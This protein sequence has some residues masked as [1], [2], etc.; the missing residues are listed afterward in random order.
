MKRNRKDFLKSKKSHRYW[1]TKTDDSFYVGGWKF[2]SPDFCNLQEV[3]NQTPKEARAKNSSYEEK[4]LSKPY[5]YGDWWYATQEN[6]IVYFVL[7]TPMFY[8]SI[9]DFEV[10]VY[11]ERLLRER[12]GIIS[13]KLRFQKIHLSNLWNVKVEK[14][15]IDRVI[16]RIIQQK[17]GIDTDLLFSE[18]NRINT[19]EDM[20]VELKMRFVSK[21]DY[22]VTIPNSWFFEK[23]YEEIF[24]ICLSARATSK[25][26]IFK[27][28][29]LSYQLKPDGIF[30]WDRIQKELYSTT[31]PTCLHGR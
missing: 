26:N 18:L 24:R 19:K 20:L 3:R 29:E 7:C 31:A 30:D 25:L 5:I 2:S 4:E 11:L 13:S 8:S 17:I 12:F 16:D 22:I 15:E 21:N 1:H 10:Q 27:W 28:D 9:E 23:T 14:K 6:R